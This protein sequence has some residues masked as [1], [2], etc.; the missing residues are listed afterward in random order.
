MIERAID[1]LQA[2]LWLSEH[3][4]IMKGFKPLHPI[5]FYKRGYQHPDG[6]R[7]YFGNPNSKDALVVASGEAMESMRASGRLDAEILEWVLSSGGKVSRLDLAVTEYIEDDLVLVK[8]VEKWFVSQL[9]ES[10]LVAGGLKEISSVSTSQGTTLETLYIGDIS[11]RGKRGIF[12]AYDK[13]VD[14]GIG[15][16]IAT[17]IELEIKREK[18]HNAATRIAESN[19]IAGNFR[20][21]FNVRADDFN[22]LMDADA[23]AIHRGK[24]QV[25]E[26]EDEE[27]ARRWDWLLSQVAPTLKRAIE[28]DRKN[29]HQDERLIKFMAASGI[30]QDARD[31][32]TYLADSKYHDKLRKNQLSDISSGKD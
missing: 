20:A 8:D 27:I 4:V 10:P 5:Q 13:G 19:D 16:E 14:L 18:A 9:I 15:S 6:F 25:K 1:Y 22:R 17:R 32:A 28:T 7:L 11:H 23:V 29:G 24:N 21:Y 2:S 26:A 12:R 31:I 3:E 30:L